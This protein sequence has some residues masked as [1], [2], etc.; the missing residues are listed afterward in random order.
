[1]QID[2]YGVL[3]S[4]MDIKKV[5]YLG[6]RVASYKVLYTNP[7]Y[8]IIKTLTFKD[9]ALQR[10]LDNENQSYELISELD[11]DYVVHILINLSFD[12]LVVNGCPF[13][14]P[15]SHLKLQGK[16]LLNTHPSY[17]PYL[18]G[19][20]PINGTLLYNY[21][22][23]AT[24]HF[25]SDEIDGGNIIYQEKVELTPD[26]DMGLCYHISFSLEETVFKK[27][28][29]VLEKNPSYV[30]EE[31]D[32]KKY[33]L[34]N[35]NASLCILDFENMSSD[36]CAQRIRA[37]GVSNEGCYGTIAGERYIIYDA[38]E[39][40]NEYILEKYSNVES[41]QVALLYDS[42]MLV[43]CFSGVLKV[44]KYEKIL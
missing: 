13:I 15:A 1:M 9:S 12:M 5:V 14:L 21:P 33:P 2:G 20:R 36:I 24:T 18:R 37:Y 40:V 38:E 29:E 11:R 16:V 28:L 17:L 42:K 23:G 4:K 39:I 44:K 10:F 7:Q 27:A 41:G 25:I 31:I 30:G 35:N 26:L 34:F 22:L 43:K 19:K 6:N 8:S 32:T 3:V